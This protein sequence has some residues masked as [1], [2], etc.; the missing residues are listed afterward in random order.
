MTLNRM[1]N[2]ISKLRSELILSYETRKLILARVQVASIT[3][4]GWVLR[5]LTYLLFDSNSRWRGFT[6]DST[7]R[8]VRES[9]RYSLSKPTIAGI[10]RAL[11]ENLSPS[12][13]LDK[14]ARKAGISERDIWEANVNII[15]PP[16]NIQTHE[17]VLAKLAKD[18][19]KSR[20][21]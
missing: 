14:L 19:P 12:A 21:L 2:F 18:W 17:E 20:P 3:G 16:K 15:E 8:W 4:V 11:R 10:D 13:A 5:G 9:T 6:S 7:S 1:K